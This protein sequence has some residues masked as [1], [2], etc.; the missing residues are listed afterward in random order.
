MLFKIVLFIFQKVVLDTIDAEESQEMQRYLSE[1]TDDPSLRDRISILTRSFQNRK[2][3]VTNDVLLFD[4]NELEITPNEGL[5]HPGSFI[6]ISVI[7]KPEK[8][9]IFE[10]TLF[11]DV[12]GRENRLPVTV[13]SIGIGPNLGCQNEDN[14]NSEN[15]TNFDN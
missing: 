15:E 9:G 6:E 2:T 1:V 12:H 5:V 10:R 14:Y 13:A 3:N 7:F 11:C 8:I 4:E